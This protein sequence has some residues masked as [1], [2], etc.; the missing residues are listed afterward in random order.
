MKRSNWVMAGALALALAT[1]ISMSMAQNIPGT[2]GKGPNAR[3]A[4]F[5]LFFISGR[6]L[7]S[8][9]SLGTRDFT[10][11]QERSRRINS[12]T[13]SPITGDDCALVWPIS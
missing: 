7:L 6:M 12:A 10:G 2:A 11:R 9:R 1:G 3:M 8:G 13:F 4:V 5:V